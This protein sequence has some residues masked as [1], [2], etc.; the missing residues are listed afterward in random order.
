MVGGGFGGLEGLG[1]ADRRPLFDGSRMIVLFFRSMHIELVSEGATLRPLLTPR[2]DGTTDTVT[3]HEV[4][5]E[6]LET[7]TDWFSLFYRRANRYSLLTKE[8]EVELAQAIE[9]GDLD[10]KE[11]LINSNLRLVISNA[12]KYQNLGLPLQ[13][14]IQEGMFGL[15]RASEKFDWR[16]G[17]KFSTYATIW[18]RQAIERALGNTS[19]VIRLPVHIGARQRKI[20]RAVEKMRNELDRDPTDEEIAHATELE[21]EQVRAALDVAKVTTSLD[22]TLQEDSETSLGDLIADERPAPEEEVEFTLRD[23]AVD[24]ALA[25]LPE[26]ERKVVELRFGLGKEEPVSQRETG[27]RLGISE[28]SARD[29]ENRALSRLSHNEDLAALREAA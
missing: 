22:Q 24:R 6:T 14:L 27:K 18:I 23:E 19:R 8:Q 25:E 20:A 7:T 28:D 21:V 2:R 3:L 29:V 11:T 12:R 5:Q 17:Y 26:V 9:R 15:I 16:R 1:G 10:A 13:D 4:P